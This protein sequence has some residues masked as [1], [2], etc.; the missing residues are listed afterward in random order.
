MTDE[1]I[2]QY[3]DSRLNEVRDEIVQHFDS[4]LSEVRAEIDQLRS[5]RSPAVSPDPDL[6]RQIDE[7]EVR[8]EALILSLLKLPLAKDF[9]GKLSATYIAIK[10]KRRQEADA[11]AQE[12][13]AWMEADGR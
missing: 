6:Q 7:V 11:A 1:Q 4:Q 13:L 9:R 2:T 12:F 3:V 8:L 5:L 10:K